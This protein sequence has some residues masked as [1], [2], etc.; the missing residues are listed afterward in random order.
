MFLRV[1]T[2][3]AELPAGHA[4]G[5][6]IWR[7]ETS[8]SASRSECGTLFVGCVALV[9]GVALLGLLLAQE[10]R[11][12]NVRQYPSRFEGKVLFHVR[13]GLLVAVSGLCILVRQHRT[14][15]ARCEVALVR[16]SSYAA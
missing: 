11:S 8:P 4:S 12:A 13:I 10:F 2:S 14:P 6:E 3:R 9:V 5:I 7:G 16:R 1:R 15:S